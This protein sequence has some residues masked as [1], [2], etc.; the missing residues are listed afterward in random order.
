MRNLDDHSMQS[1]YALFQA[2]RKYYTDAQKIA[3][4]YE[5]PLKWPYPVLWNKAE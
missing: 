5:K 3:Y 4:G 1:K 2:S